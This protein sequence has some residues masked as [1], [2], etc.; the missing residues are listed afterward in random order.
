MISIWRTTMALTSRIYWKKCWVL[1]LVKRRKHLVDFIRD[2]ETDLV[3][4]YTD[5]QE[6]VPTAPN[7]VEPF[8]NP[9]PPARFQ[10]VQ[11]AV[12][13]GI[14]VFRIIDPFIVLLTYLLIRPLAL[15][16]LFW[17]GSASDHRPHTPITTI[18][19]YSTIGKQS[20]SYDLL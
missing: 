9:T 14:P 11:G 7:I 2:K 6:K 12:Q 15:F 20:K 16:L 13:E 4:K 19:Q 1:V 5:S 10:T 18:F 8:T 17:L 3:N